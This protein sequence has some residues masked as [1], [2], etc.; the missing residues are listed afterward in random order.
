MS[1]VLICAAI[2][3]DVAEVQRFFREGAPISLLEESARIAMSVALRLGYSPA[4]KC[5]I[6]GGGAD[7]DAVIR[8]ED[9]HITVLSLAARYGNYPL[10]Q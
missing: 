8:F 9:Q 1:A 5:L 10:A 4:V 7:I 6:K 2:E 3:G